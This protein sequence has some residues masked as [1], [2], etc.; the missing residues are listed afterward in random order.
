MWKK[1]ETGAELRAYLDELEERRND[2]EK[3]R[4]YKREQQRAWRAK[5]RDRLREYEK[6]RQAGKYARRKTDP[7]VRAARRRQ[8]RR[9]NLKKYGLTPQCVA[10]MVTAQGG[11]CATCKADVAASP[12]VD[13]CH[14]TGKVRAILCRK[15]NLALGLA[16][17]NPETLKALAAYLEHHQ[18][19]KPWNHKTIVILSRNP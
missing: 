18:T 11:M 10:A 16:G 1:F 8:A 12:C 9:Y 13:H 17:D 3:M 7:S 19:K 6:R 2:P 15:C 14:T 4:A 5:N